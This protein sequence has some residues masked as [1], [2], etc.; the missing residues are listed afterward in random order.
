[1][2]KFLLRSELYRLLQRELPEDVYPDGS[3][4]Q[5]YHT[6]DMDAVA[7]AIAS[8]YSSMSSVYDNLFITTCDEKIGAFETS[9]F[10]ETSPGL[11]LAARKARILSKIRSTEDISYWQI[12]TTTATILAGVW[13]EVRPRVGRGSPTPAM[14]KGLAAD[15]VWAP[16]WVSGQAFPAGVTGFDILRTDQTALLNLR[17]TT[18]TYDVFI[19]SAALDDSLLQLLDRT[20]S[21]QEP[22]RS[23]HT[24][25]VINPSDLDFGNPIAEPTRFS[26]TLSLYYSPD[27]SQVFGRSTLWFG[28]LDDPTSLGFGD[29]V[30]TGQIVE[31]VTPAFGFLDAVGSNAQNNGIGFGDSEATNLG[32]T[33][34]LVAF[35]GGGFLFLPD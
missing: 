5:Y 9:Y 29:A 22:A 30:A 23:R 19:F 4:S 26:D 32:G 31:R 21:L 33:M 18:Y 6:A 7:G 1:M 13:V 27:G 15:D 20:L 3:P 34:T 25:T 16:G 10:A 24:I 14:I 8:C 28:F 17:K 11:N 2:A 35:S 12:L